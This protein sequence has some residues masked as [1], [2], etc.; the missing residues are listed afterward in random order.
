MTPVLLGHAPARPPRRAH[1]HSHRPRTTWLLR[2]AAPRGLCVIHPPVDV[3]RTF[4]PARGD[5]PMTHI[6]THIRRNASLEGLEARRLLAGQLDTIAA[7]DF[8]NDDKVDVV[9]SGLMLLGRGDG[10][11]ADGPALGINLANADRLL[12]ADFNKDGNA[13]LA[14]LD[15]PQIA[16]H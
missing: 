13:D 3:T 2:G 9:A 5:T 10:T 1:S 15:G 7:A 6:M 16:V 12:A 14:V 4:R 11:F 8:N